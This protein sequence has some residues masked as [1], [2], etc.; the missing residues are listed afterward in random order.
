ML[1]FLSNKQNLYNKYV[2]LISPS[3]SPCM[4]YNDYYTQ[5]QAKNLV[6]ESR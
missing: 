6:F 3:Y 1:N 5:L 4:L 2:V